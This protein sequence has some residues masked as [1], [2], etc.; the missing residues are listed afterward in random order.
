MSKKTCLGALL[1]ICVMIGNV[2]AFHNEVQA[3][4]EVEKK[5]I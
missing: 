5:Y 4:P 2:R 1:L 3:M